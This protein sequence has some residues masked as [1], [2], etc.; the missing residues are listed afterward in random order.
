MMNLLVK[1][2][3]P[4]AFLLISQVSF[5][6]AEFG[7]IGLVLK[8]NKLGLEVLSVLPGG[9]AQRA[10]IKVNDVITHV[11]GKPVNHTTFSSSLASIKGTEG[12]QVS[13]TILEPRHK[14][15]MIIGVVRQIIDPSD[16]LNH[17]YEAKNPK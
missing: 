2:V 8:S 14:S 6:S 9:P 16:I 17:H 7:G 10:G 11:D 3:F 1:L 4:A 12:S 5:A 15:K 13:L